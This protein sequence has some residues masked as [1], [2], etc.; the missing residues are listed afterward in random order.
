MTRVANWFESHRRDLPWREAGAG[1]WGVLVS[2]VMLQQ[3]PVSRVLPVY[4]Y[5]MARWPSP[6]HL[7]RESLSEVLVAWDRMGY[8]RRA[9]RLQEAAVAI[10]ARHGGRVPEGLDDL[11]ALPGVGDYTARAVRCF[12]FGIPEP[13]VDT[14]VRRVVARSVGGHGEAGP[15]RTTSDRAKVSALLETL[16]D[17]H[18]KTIAVAGLME[19]GALV[20]Q[21]RTPQCDV[22]PIA[23]LC[24]WRAQGYRVYD[25]PVAAKQPRYEGS[26]RQVRGILLR[27]LRNSDLPIPGDFLLSR[28]PQTD[29]ARRALGSLIA[30]GLVEAAPDEPGSYRISSSRNTEQA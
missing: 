25:G 23:S 7:A 24:Q 5:W 29:Q 6:E 16:S 22:C 15:P 13:V 19:L 8:P 17:E 28:W 21:A 9:K 3:T 14:N 11:L 30:D 27:E 20:C 10:V 18:T 4:T 1:S 2:E 26:D 12:A